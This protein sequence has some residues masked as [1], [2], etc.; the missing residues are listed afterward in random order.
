VINAFVAYGPQR[1]LGLD[2]TSRRHGG[3]DAE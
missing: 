1:Q 2:R 3:V